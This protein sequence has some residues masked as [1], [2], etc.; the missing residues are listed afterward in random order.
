MSKFEMDVDLKNY[1]SEDDAINDFCRKAI[2]YFG[3]LKITKNENRLLLSIEY[4]KLIKTEVVKE[5]KKI[6]LRVNPFKGKVVN[7]IE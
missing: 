5:A 1:K 7:N 2:N 4:N 6:N 3:D